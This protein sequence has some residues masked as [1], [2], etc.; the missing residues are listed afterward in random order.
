MFSPL[1][2]ELFKIAILED[3]GSG[4]I[5]SQLLVP[6]NLNAKA[7]II[8]KERIILAGI[9]FVKRFFYILS[10]FFNL[11]HDKLQ[12]EE[13]YGEG[14]FVDEGKVIAE[15]WGNARILVAGE[16]IAL[17]ILQRLSGIAT[18]TATFVKRIK[19]LNV[20]IL[21][22]RKT[23]P[24]L[25]AMEKY[26]VCVG[27]GYNHRFALYDAI[28]IK[29][30]HIK[31]VGSVSNALKMVKKSNIYQK[32]EIEVKNLEELKEAILEGADIVMLDNMDI[33]TMK[34]AVK[35]AKGKVFLEASGGVTLDNVYEIASTGIDFISIGALTHSAKAVD[36]SMKIKEIL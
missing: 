2:D 30:N 31:I 4:D 27:G 25:R 13:Y 21:D 10:S 6:E 20:K 18:L 17:N 1:T 33:E 8:C 19:D 5:T 7:H 26:A 35:L 23:T 15:L 14:D 16:R 9:P 28:L 32:I 36:I 22:T 29:D 24:G 3:I 34:K 11:K 12:I